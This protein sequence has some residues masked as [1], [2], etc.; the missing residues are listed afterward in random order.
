MGRGS[1]FVGHFPPTNQYL[2]GFFFPPSQLL[3]RGTVQLEITFLKRS[4]NRFPIFLL[5]KLQQ[6][7][8]L[9]VLRNFTKCSLSVL[10][11]TYG[12]EVSPQLVKYTKP[13]RGNP[14]TYIN[15]FRRIARKIS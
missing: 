13:D 14:K 5:H 10:L 7:V 9:N 11:L 3:Y 4:D 8:N 1:S 15:I 2:K 6:K 12:F